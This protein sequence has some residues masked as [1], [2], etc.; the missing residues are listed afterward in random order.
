MRG[1]AARLLGVLPVLLL[2]MAGG[3]AHGMDDGALM[4]AH[5]GGTLRLT[6]ASSGG[7]VDP[8]IA[9][10]QQNLQ[11]GAPVYDGLMAFPKSGRGDAVRPV[12]DLA[13]GMPE[14]RDGGR[15]YVFRLRQGIRFSDGH[16]LGVE[17]VV[18]TMRRIFRVNSPAAGPYFS[19]LVGAAPCLA[20]Q[21]RCDLS[22][23]VV[24]DAAAGTV[25]FHLARPDTDFLYKLAFPQAAIVPAGT[26]DHDTGNVAPPGTGP[27]RITFYDPD[28][29]MRL[30]RNPYFR[31]WDGLAQP[32]GFPD[33]IVYSFGLDEEAEVTAVENGQYDW[34]LD[35]PPRDRLGELGDRYVP[36]V[37]LSDMLV[38][39]YMEMNVRLA[40]FDVPEV[41]RALNDAVDRHAMVLHEGGPALAYPAC[42]MIPRGIPSHDPECA[43]GRGASVAHPAPSWQG[44]D[45]AR[46]RALVAASGTAGQ[47][48]TIV[49]MNTSMG[50]VLGQAVRETL[51]ELGYHAIVRPITPVV[52]FSYLQNTSNA[53]QI[54]FTG[55][56]ADY[57]APGAFL[58]TLFACDSFHPSSDNSL[59]MSGFCDPAIDR[60][61]DDAAAAQQGDPVR[62]D[63][64]WQQADAAIMAQ[65]PVVPLVQTRRLD[66]VSARVGHVLSSA[67]YMVLLA[68]LWVH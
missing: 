8:Q 50:R 36:R 40:P 24:T 26:P 51:A 41:R 27:Y 58:H 48:V 42:D 46:A 62:A 12:P 56:Q 47:D 10:E 53:V 35:M 52:E 28:R 15:T 6:A 17:D 1:V 57:P 55:W 2:G 4:A 22:N 13:D 63:A 67:Y 14:I 30:E 19:N 59:N 37:H 9:Y 29:V 38:V 64:M 34:M 54:G 65:A 23:G 7:S 16:V 18:A 44:V 43:Y 25:T 32:D 66:L 20:G 3:A 61:M 31:V 33:R 5:R 11:I 21:G 60:L 45:M 39:W 49:T 68:Q